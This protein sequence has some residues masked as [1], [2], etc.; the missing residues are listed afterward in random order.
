MKIKVLL[1]F[2]ALQLNAA[3][4][5][6]P[7][8]DFYGEGAS[9]DHP[10]LAPFI[11]HLSFRNIC[12]HIIDQ[13]LEWFDPDDVRQGD[14]IY[15]NMWFLEWF[16]E[17][18]HDQ[19]QYPYILVSGDVGAWAPHPRIK[20]F[21]YD[22]KLAAWFCRNL[23]FSNHPKLFQIPM[24]PDLCLFFLYHSVVEDLL[25]AHEI[26]SSFPKEHLLYM[27]FYPRPHGDRDKI[28]Q[29]FAD[30]PYCFSLHQNTYQ[31]KPSF[32][33]QMASSKFVL[34]PLGLETD[35]VRTWEALIFDSIPI[36]EH[37]F[38]DPLFEGLP[39]LIV[40]DWTEIDQ[41]LLEKKYEELKDLN[42]DKAYFAYWE[43]LIKK[44]QT[45]V[46]NNHTE[47]AELE[48]TLFKEEDLELIKTILQGRPSPLIYKGFLSTLR[49]WQVAALASQKVELYDPWLDHKMFF[50]LCENKYLQ[51]QVSLISSE[52][53]FSEKTEGEE[54]ASVFLDLTYYRTSLKLFFTTSV[55]HIGNFRHSLKIDLEDLYDDLAP[56]ALLFGN[57]GDDPYVQK[58]LKLFGEEKQVQIERTGS[59]WSVIKQKRSF[60]LEQIFPNPYSP[61]KEQPLPS[62]FP[63]EI[64]HDPIFESLIENHEIKNV[65]YIGSSVEEAALDLGSLIPSDG[66]IIAIDA[67]PDEHEYLQFLSNAI[68]AQLTDRV[69]P[70]QMDPLKAARKMKELDLNLD[71]IFLEGPQDD[72]STYELLY[73]WTFYIK[74]SGLTCG[75]GWNTYEVQRDVNQFAF[76]N[77]RIVHSNGNFWMFL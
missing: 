13:N 60:L 26:K 44:T 10:G 62:T 33:G 67:C 51:Y 61:I 11:G 17:N 47:F 52:K 40:H 73:A 43:D 5:K 18:V 35:C 36:V 39:V 7:A 68:H 16:T 46:R 19:I 32:Y 1:F 25:R 28:A 53:E 30:K 12:D 48:A 4:I 38:L 69:I 29:L 57:M 34:S 42:R 41:P 55:C 20:E 77:N 14:L 66:K 63:R 71:L 50:Y 23:V 65:I 54:N 3:L 15:L 56:G 31:Y 72:F 27:N 9:S 22:P 64:S 74:N 2:C 21:L 6:V 45:K 8:K 49:P 24:G 70:V 37:T 76:E 58:V 75:S 59:F